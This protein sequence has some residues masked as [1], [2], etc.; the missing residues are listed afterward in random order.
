[1]SCRYRRPPLTEVVWNLD[2]VPANWLVP[3]FADTISAGVGDLYPRR[4]SAG[5]GGTVFEVDTEGKLG[6]T[7]E[8]TERTR[9]LSQDESAILEADPGTLTLR[10]LPPYTGWADLRT[11]A[12]Q[13]MSAFWEASEP[14]RVAGM[15]LRYVNR[16]VVPAPGN[17]VV[18]SDWVRFRP[19]G[20]DFGGA[21]PIAA[22][23]VAVEAPFEEGRDILRV[24]LTST[25]TDGAGAAA[26]ILDLSYDRE[27]AGSVSVDDILPWLDLA[28]DRICQAFEGCITDRLRE[29]FDEE[30]PQ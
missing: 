24:E 19:E 23:V 4:C 20:L 30:Q 18:L 17:G 11:V 7:L 14:V 2:V 25:A 10:K 21:F 13:A 22:F 28:H 16:I 15:A 29:R 6:R 8:A 1:M 3:S 12:R 9:F 26:F 27:Q 5:T